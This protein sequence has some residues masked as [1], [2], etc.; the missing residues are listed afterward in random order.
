M[1]AT[2]SIKLRVDELPK[3][4]SKVEFFMFRAMEQKGMDFYKISQQ[5]K[6]TESVALLEDVKSGKMTKE[7]LESLVGK[8]Y[9]E[10]LMLG[11]K[12]EDVNRIGTDVYKIAQMAHLFDTIKNSLI[13]NHVTDY[14]EKAKTLRNDKREEAANYYEEFAANL[15]NMLNTW[16]QIAP[17]FL[18]SSDI[19]NVRTKFKLDAEGM[20]SLSE[21][22]DDE[23]KMLNKMVFDRPANEINPIDDVDKAVELFLKSIHVQDAYD[24]YGYTVNV[25]YANFI[26]NI[27]NDVQ[28]SVG[29]EEVLDKLKKNVDKV[30]EYQQIIDKFAYK[31]N[32]TAEETQFRVNFTN[33]FAKAFFPIGIVSIEKQGNSL[34]FKVLEAASG[35]LSVYEKIIGSHFTSRGMRV[36]DGEKVI[37][38][39]HQNEKG[40]WVLTKEDIPKIEAFLDRSTISDAEFKRRRV[41]FLKGLGFDFSPQTEEYFK[42]SSYLGSIN[43]NVKTGKFNYIYNHL[44]KS[45][46]PQENKTDVI[47]LDP[48]KTIKQK[49]KNLSKEEEKQDDV[50]WRGQNNNIVDIINEE[51]KNNTSYNIEKS[52]I[53]ADGNRMHA[54]QLHNNFSILNKFLSDSD[55]YKNLE[56]VLKE[57]SMFWLDPAKNP[58]IR[59]DYYL[60]SLFYLDPNSENYGQRRKVKNGKYSTDADAEPVVLTLRNTGGLQLKLLDDF[61]KEGASSTS[62]NE[63]DKILQDIHGFFAQSKG[64]AGMLRLGD[65]S[66]DLGIS[67]N[68]GLDAE[69]GQP[70]DYGKPLGKATIDANTI[71]TNNAFK[72]NIKNAIVDYVQMRYLGERGFFKSQ[73]GQSGLTMGEKNYENWSYFDDILG[74]DTKKAIDE[75]VKKLA[76]NPDENNVEMIATELKTKSFDEKFDRDILNYFTKKSNSLFDKINDVR[77]KF[78]LSDFSLIGRNNLRGN[79]A[80]FVANTF[81]TDL[82]QMKLFFGD[83]MYFKAFTKRASKDSATGKFTMMDDRLLEDLNNEGNTQGYGAYTNLSAKRFIDRVYQSQMEELENSDMSEEEKKALKKQYET[84]RDQAL[85]KQVVSRSFKSAVLKDIIFDSEQVYKISNNID[86]LMNS[87]KGYISD[88]MRALYQNS[89][90][91]VIMDKYMGGNEADGQGKCTFDFYRIMSIATSSWLP[92]QEAVYKKIVEYNHYDELADETTDD[93]KRLEYIQ[94]RDAVGYDPTE[95]VYF[96]PKKFQYSGPEQYDR[97]IDGVEYNTAAPIFDKFSLQPLIPTVIKKGSIKT[98]D[99]FLNR[100]M[101]YNGVGYVKFESGSKVETPSDKDDFYSKYDKTSPNARE[102]SNFDPKAVFKSEQELFFN[103]FKE[104]VTIDAEIHDN[105]IFGSQIRKLILMNL[106]RPEFVEMANKY[107]NFLGQLAQLEKTSLYREM[108]IQKVGDRLRITDMKKIVDYFFNEINKKDQDINVKKALKFDETTG[109]FEIPL[110]AA[111][112]AQVLEGIIISAINNRVVRYKTNGSMLVQMAE[113]GSEGVKFDKSSSA[114]ALQTYGDDNL[115]YYDL[116]DDGQGGYTVSKMDVKIAL[117]GQWLGLLNLDGLDKRKIGSIERLN[118][119]LKNDDWRKLHEKKLSMIAYRIPTQGR[120]FLDVML[121][122]E[123]LPASVGDAIV[124]PREVVIKSG[125]D[126]DIDKMFVF[127]PNLTEKGNYMDGNY[128]DADLNDPD[129]YKDLKGVIQNKLYETMADIILHPSNYMELVTPSFNFHIL[130]LLD[131]IFERLGMKEEGKDRKPTDHKNTKILERELNYQKFL[132]LLKGKNDLGIAAV[133]NTFNALFQLANASANTSF[134]SKKSI[135]TFFT[136]LYVEKTNNYVRGIDFSSIFDEDN[137][138]KS[139][140]FSEFISAFVDVAN[141]DYVFAANIVTELSPI[142]FYMKFAGI[143]S[144]KILNFMNQPA[145]REYTKT[146]SLYQNKF[147]KLNNMGIEETEDEENKKGARRLAMSDVLNSL[148]YINLKDLNGNYTKESIEDYINERKK[149]FGITDLDVYFTEEKLLDSIK[150]DKTKISDLTEEEKLVQLAMILELENLKEQS[151]SITEAQRILNFDTNPF[152][153]SFDVYSRSEAYK[154]AVADTQYSSGNNILSADAFNYIRRK[155]MISSLDMSTDIAHILSDLFPV[156]NDITFNKFLFDRIGDLK[157]NKIFQTQDDMLKFARTAKNDYINYVLQNNISKSEA[158]M[159]FF[160]ETFETDKGFNEYLI[161]LVQTRKLVDMWNAIKDREDFKEITA[162]DQFP[163]VKNIVNTIGTNENRVN[164]FAIIEGSSNR[165]EKDSIISQFDRLCNLSDPDLKPIKDFFKNLALYSIFQSGLNT[166]DVSYTAITPVGIVNKLYGYAM[167]ERNKEYAN[168]DGKQKY[169]LFKDFSQLFTENNPTFFNLPSVATPTREVSSRGK[170]Y[171]KDVKFVWQSTAEKNGLPKAEPTWVKGLANVPQNKVSGVESFGSTVTANDETIKALGPAPHS[172]DMVIGGYRTRTTR[173]AKEMEKYNVKVGDLIKHIGT[174]ADGTLK[175]VMARVTAIHDYLT[176]GW[177]G[178]WEKEGWRA[179]DADV[180]NKFN[181][182]AAAIEFE[183]VSIPNGPEEAEKMMLAVGARKVANSWLQI[184][185]QHWFVEPG[186]YT[187]LEKPGSRQEL[188]INDNVGDELYIG[189]R[190]VGTKNFISNKEKAKPAVTVKGINIRSDKENPNSLANRLTN[191]NWYSSGLMDVEAPYKAGKTGVLRDD[192]NLMY[193]LQVEKFQKNPELIDEINA[194][195]GL[196]FIQNSSHEVG[197]EGSRWEGKGMESNFIKVLAK[198]YEKVAKDLGK[199]IETSQQPTTL[200]INPEAAKYSNYSG[201]A[202]GGDA[203]WAAEGKKVGI[204]KQV[205]YRPETLDKL[206]PE[207]YQE[208]EDA[209][210]AA[211]KALDRPFLDPKSK[212]SKIAYAGKLMTR[213]YLQAKAADAVFAISDILNPGEIGKPSSKGIKYENKAGKQV[214][215]GGTGYAVE[216]AIQLGNRSVYV[217][218]QGT[219]SNHKTAVGWY[220][221]DGKQFVATEIPTLTKKYAG[222]GTRHLN[223][224]GAQAIRNVYQKTFGGV[225]ITSQQT[226]QTTNTTPK[227]LK[228]ED[229]LIIAENVISKAETIRIAQQSKQVIEETSFKQT[230]GSVSWGYGK[231]WMRINAMSEKQREGLV[232]GKQLN[233]VEITQKMKEEFIKTGNSK[234]FPLYGYT[235]ID[236]NGN[237]LPSIPQDII[238]YL[239]SMGIDVSQYDASYNSVYDKSDN[240]S[241]IIHQDN[242]ETNKS[243]IITISLGRPMKFITYELKDSNDF[244]VADTNN[245]AFRIAVNAVQGE[246]LKLNLIPASA[247]DAKGNI[248]YGHLTPDTLLKYAEQI[249]KIK[250]TNLK[251]FVIDKLKEQFKNAEKTE[252]TLNNGAVL[253]FSGNNRNVFHEIVFDPETNAKAMEVGFPSLKINKAFKGLGQKDNIVSTNDYR[254]VLTLRKVE[255]ET[256]TNVVNQEKFVATTTEEKKI[257]KKPFERTFVPPTRDAQ[258]NV[259]N[260]MEEK[261][262]NWIEKELPWSIFTPASEIAEMYKKEKESTETIEEFLNRLSCLGKLI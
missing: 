225:L 33:S 134:L 39:A 138:L 187:V 65:K 49:V 52:V 82:S 47:I 117:T 155:S 168:L 136:S 36:N 156:R 251:Q 114:K 31:E 163:F 19:F 236:K 10:V 79:V 73:D 43:A 148:G 37:N 203:T 3:L 123:F 55:K 12:L 262:K 53:T 92:E 40:V 126:F 67:L 164:A 175:E 71:F 122:K 119:A 16:D 199:F 235:T 86:K 165:V 121:V 72:N 7:N 219:D 44:I 93:D 46:L 249:D 13:P 29:L 145:I 229:G 110:D 64:Y 222:V 133:A 260:D 157:R 5:P 38:L 59:S 20:I 115:K 8:K 205:D 204:G 24:E 224:A 233:G 131:K 2:C 216:M 227:I 22:A 54:I 35:K 244:S 140:F 28:N 4:F 63:L 135:K 182:G 70:I 91:Q 9:A 85:M 99:W 200:T 18:A 153:S 21:V 190:R 215:D 62:L 17:N 68:Y 147:I 56:D 15:Q 180:L 212:N 174:S 129:K 51:L 257:P 66:T 258:G 166:S 84:Q 198:S 228:N 107:S 197:V 111:V 152:A 96:P 95:T 171:A 234:G 185:G 176:P 181:A 193:K 74:K 183:L 170:W 211:A 120:N 202:P 32:P 254:I 184:D 226:K 192:M 177:K 256:L 210:R 87:S 42:N 146:L 128:T 116:I 252:Y 113:T 27:F 172:I 230:A 261:I 30:P 250:G 1:S 139:E 245:T 106:D 195:G 201:A 61:E 100:K 191:P 209:Y 75:Y 78:G 221:W 150:K 130:P 259:I 246:A 26:K 105:A 179:E 217:F 189:S 101:E 81:I 253:V 94:K 76:D 158:G 125:S 231:Q 167:D 141:D 34:A 137:V 112:Q 238:N 151:N 6:T 194:Q 159:K 239:S 232:I 25:D 69:T 124:M 83:A 188:Y 90:G 57:P 104:Q 48:I 41:E 196:A 173:S 218:H 241:L 132:S 144:G 213:D 255:G 237:K 223:E 247:K 242:T 162:D 127:Y 208:C 108:G 207:Q 11:S 178:T 98:S 103:H 154:E 206:K 149:A 88:Q 160:H 109:K 58:N 161:E 220:K 248:K 243:P 89:V 214:V 60:N 142:M 169:E 240:G 118:E 80:Y 77:A 23:K 97:I 45:L 186:K 50:R 102:V 14:I 143:G